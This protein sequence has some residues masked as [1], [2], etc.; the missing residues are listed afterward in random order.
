MSKDDFAVWKGRDKRSIAAQADLDDR[1]PEALGPPYRLSLSSA[2]TG[3][4]GG[5][6][7]LRVGLGE[8]VG[9]GGKVLDDRGREVF[10]ERE[11]LAADADAREARIEVARVGREG[12]A[13]AVKV[14]GDVRAARP[15]EGSNQLDGRG[16]F[17]H[18]GGIGLVERGEGREWSAGGKNREAFGTGAAEEAKEE[19]FGPVVGGM[20]CGDGLGAGVGGGLEEGAEASVPRSSLEV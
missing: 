12:E 3:E 5:F 6:E 16:V 8:H 14:R 13:M 20:A 19:G 1:L 11:E 17:E 9:E 2:K 15:K 10:E 4:R 7:A 18:W